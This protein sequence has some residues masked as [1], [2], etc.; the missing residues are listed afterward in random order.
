MKNNQ[1]SYIYWYNP[2]M[3][4][5]QQYANKEYTNNVFGFKLW[6]PYNFI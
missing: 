5:A 2:G 3:T 1:E 6:L 4:G